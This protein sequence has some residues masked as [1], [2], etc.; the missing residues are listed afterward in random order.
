[1]GRK[2]A[3]ATACLCV[4]I[5]Y[6]HFEKEKISREMVLFLLGQYSL[7]GSC[8]CFFILT[9]IFFHS[10]YTTAPGRGRG[11]SRVSI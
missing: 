3:T 6:V 1:M 4:S 5:R 11:P 8:F 2:K 7:G 10:R 9:Y